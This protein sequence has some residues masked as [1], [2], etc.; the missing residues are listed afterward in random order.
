[1]SFLEYFQYTF[2]Y[3]RNLNPI[4]SKRRLTDK[5]SNMKVILLLCLGKRRSSNF[6]IC[7]ANLLSF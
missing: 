4:P 1:M 3:W 2:F 6:T 7:M 5:V